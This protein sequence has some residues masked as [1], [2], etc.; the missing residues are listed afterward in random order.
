MTYNLEANENYQ[1]PKKPYADIILK[2][3]HTTKSMDFI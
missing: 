3:V 1:F 2:I